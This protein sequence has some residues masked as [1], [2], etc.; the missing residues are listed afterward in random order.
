[1]NAEIG[2]TRF[3]DQCRAEE[4][5]GGDAGGR[6][7]GRSLRRRRQEQRSGTWCDP[8][9]GA[10]HGGAASSDGTWS[11]G[12]SGAA[13][14]RTEAS[15]ASTILSTTAW[16]DS[17][18]PRGAWWLMAISSGGRARW[19]MPAGHLELRDPSWGAWPGWSGPR[20]SFEASREPPRAGGVPTHVRAV[21]IPLGRGSG[22]RRFPQSVENGADVG[23]RGVKNDP[24]GAP[25]VRPFTRCRTSRSRTEKTCEILETGHRAGR[26]VGDDSWFP[27][28]CV[29]RPGLPTI[30][31]DAMPRVVVVGPRTGGIR[32][33]ARALRPGERAG[34]RRAGRLDTPR[35]R[36]LALA[37]ACWRS[38]VG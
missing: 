4:G 9:V 30:V 35:K 33:A 13:V 15:I 20:N 2:R 17:R 11:A 27:P 8:V 22:A 31:R 37:A 1:M 23:T 24:Y 19:E 25:R 5:R 36:D 16:V 14:A 3:G 6:C 26:V 32:P 21:F 29:H 38:S 10:G 28:V 7:A 34:C 12:G 18:R